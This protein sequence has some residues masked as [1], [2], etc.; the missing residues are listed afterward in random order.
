LAIKTM[1]VL[2]FTVSNLVLHKAIY[3]AHARKILKKIDVAKKTLIDSQD[4]GRLLISTSW[5]KDSCV[6]M[7]I[8]IKTLDEVNL[9]YMPGAMLPGYEDM[10]NYFLSQKNVIYHEP[11]PP[12]TL[13]EYIQWLKVSGLSHNRT[14]SQQEKAVSTHK[15]DLC[16][17][18]MIENN[19]HV[20]SWGLR[21]DESILRN[22][23]LSKK[24]LIYQLKNG[25]YRS[26]PLA[27]FTVDDIWAY[28]F[29]NDLPYHP[30]YD[31]ETDGYTRRTIRN[32]GWLT[33]DGLNQYGE[34]RLQW[35][36]KHYFDQFLQLITIFPELNKNM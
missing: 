22:R 4:I 33:T 20:L 24:G 3:K 1:G 27:Y 14:N 6:L 15:R 31:K 29:S 8:A 28:I 35:L 26:S 34:N 13:D 11:P 2:L 30:L 36:K 5:G 12:K 7:D 17:D 10:K 18:W 21:K 23:L 32:S 19:F 9:Y 25:I 16:I